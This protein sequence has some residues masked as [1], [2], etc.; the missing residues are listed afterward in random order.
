L[1]R[2]LAEAGE[3]LVGLFGDLEL[4]DPTAWKLTAGWRPNRIVGAEVLYVDFNEAAADRYFGAQVD[5]AGVH[6]RAHANAWVVSALL[7]VP[8]RWPLF[9]VYGKFGV[10]QLDDSFEASGFH[11]FVP[12]CRPPTVCTYSREQDDLQPHVGIGARGKI[13][14][15]VWLSVEYEATDRDNEDPITMLSFGVAWGF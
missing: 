3:P 11:Y 15:T 4:D 5:Y 9:D 8:E 1:D 12:E 6:A 2:S 13:T 10:A 14:G 7:F